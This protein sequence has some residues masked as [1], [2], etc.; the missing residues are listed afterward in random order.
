MVMREMAASLPSGSQ[1]D[2]DKREY[3]TPDCRQRTER[4][5]TNAGL[6]DVLPLGWV[7]ERK[8]GCH[9]VRLSQTRVWLLLQWSVFG[10]PASASQ[11]NRGA[12]G[13]RESLYRGLGG[14]RNDT[15]HPSSHRQ[16]H[17]PATT[18]TLAEGTFNASPPLLTRSA[19]PRVA[20]SL[21]RHWRVENALGIKVTEQPHTNA[22]G[23]AKQTAYDRHTGQLEL[24]DHAGRQFDPGLLQLGVAQRCS[25]GF[26]QHL[27]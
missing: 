17:L 15:N 8:R 2:E 26:V 12:P 7:E 13:V 22:A 16:D 27:Q 9:S 3:H 4:H 21:L 18:H 25:I 5:P 19:R 1:S 6:I 20:R 11:V 24:G 14:R 23:A 10:A